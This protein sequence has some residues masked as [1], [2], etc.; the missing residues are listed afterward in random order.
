M[1]TKPPFRGSASL[2]LAKL[3]DDE[4]KVMGFI[5]KKH[6]VGMSQYD[7]AAVTGLSRSMVAKVEAAALAKI[8]RALLE[9]A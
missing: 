3:D 5:L 1:A 4:R 8:R 2:G 9:V 6:G 7:T